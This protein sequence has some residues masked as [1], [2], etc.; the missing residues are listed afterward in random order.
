MVGLGEPGAGGHGL[1][2]VVGP[3]QSTVQEVGQR[4]QTDVD[5]GRGQML[6]ESQVA[7]V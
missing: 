3:H 6:R 7:W 4:V 2:E 5:S 1:L